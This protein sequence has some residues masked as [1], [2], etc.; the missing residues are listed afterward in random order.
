MLFVQI[1]ANKLPASLCAQSSD[2]NET[3]AK[4]FLIGE[5]S[6]L[7]PQLD[8]TSI[9]MNLLLQAMQHF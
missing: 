1:E 4:H 2:P 9:A 8:F 6:I 3:E 7:L 5:S